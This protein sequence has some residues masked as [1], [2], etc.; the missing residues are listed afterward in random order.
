MLALAPALVLNAQS[1]GGG[2]LREHIQAGVRARDEHRFED[3]AREFSAAAR[4]AP[5]QAEIHAALGLTRHR[6]G[7]LTA[8][9]ESLERA[10]ELKPGLS[11]VHG[12]LGF[13]LFTLGRVEE[14]VEHLEIGK[15]ETPGNPDITSWLGVAYLKS[16]RYREAIEQLESV[17]PAKPDDINILLYLRQA[18][19][20]VSDDAR[21]EDMRRRI[22]ELDPSRA[23]TRPAARG[24]DAQASAVPSAPSGHRE[25]E[26]RAACTQCHRWSPPSTLPKDA[27]LGAV[28]KMYGLAN[29]GGL[30][31]S[32]GHPIEGLELGEVAA[33]FETLAPDRLDTPAWRPAPSE[34]PI[35]FERR[36]LLGVPP[37]DKLPGTS[38]VR[39]L[40]LFDDLEGPELVV[41]DML[42]G[43]VSW[44]DPD[45]P[46]AKLN[47]LARL[48]N[49]DHVEA[50][51]L[52]G[53]GRTDLLVADLGAVMPSERTD[54]AI[55]WLRAVGERRFEVVRLAENLGR[56]ADVQAA[57]FDGDGDLDIVA[58]VF[59]WISVGRIVYLE[60]LSS[61]ASKGAPP[62]FRLTTIDDRPGTIHTPIVDLN[63]DGRPD[64]LALISQH[65]ETVVAF[66]NV[67]SGRFEQQEVFTAPHPH[68]GTSGI[69][70]ADL[71][72]DGDL[73]VLLTNGDTMDD[74]L[75]FKPYQGLA[76]LENR[77]GY[78]FVHHAIDRYYGAMRAETGD[79]DGDGDLDIVAS[80]WIPELSEA[81]R[82]AMN[83]PGVVWYEQ[84]SKGSFE[85]HVLS[86][87]ACDHAT[88]EI[89]D[90]DG[91]GRLEVIVGTVWLGKVPTGRPP[92][93]VEIWKRA[94]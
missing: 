46:N 39:L 38:N 90:I 94:K 62:S 67:G 34:S 11:G 37:G 15:R 86:H 87:D 60:N 74:M 64:F 93:S 18:Y 8:A 80:S 89:G 6:Q 36:T 14:A 7:N 53:D 68:W 84:T 61:P 4:L 22:A 56:V 3:A 17:R 79:L 83:V 63:G 9:V 35:T 30:L 23:K 81:D 78:P 92:V 85:A 57:G 2:E 75:Q 77:G 27:W 13:D 76:W 33:Y 48:A 69:E 5:N 91:D 44:T 20:A 70:A 73:D 31:A 21:E 1:A 28:A 32:D 12:L 65:H 88:L 50:A 49:P 41:C 26:I 25:P 72:G 29:E 51:D 54:G 82:K 40:E 47:P 24:A 58:A 10:L 43:W 45:D 71:D 52:D 59:G 55:V 66:L 42:S 16:S 19:A